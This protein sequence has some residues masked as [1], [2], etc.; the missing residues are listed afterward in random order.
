MNII[1]INYND[2]VICDEGQLEV[3]S[4]HGDRIQLIPFTVGLIEIF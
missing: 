4:R 2:S 3:Q 1:R